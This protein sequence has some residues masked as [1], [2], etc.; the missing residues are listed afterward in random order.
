MENSKW[1]T[2]ES[3]DYEPNKARFEPYKHVSAVEIAAGG[4][5][6]EAD[7]QNKSTPQ[8]SKGRRN[9]NNQGNRAKANKPKANYYGKGKGRAN[10]THNGHRNHQNGKNKAQGS[11]LPHARLAN[12]LPSMSGDL[13]QQQEADFLI[14]P[15]DGLPE[16]LYIELILK[17]QGKEISRSEWEHMVEG[18]IVGLCMS[19]ESQP[20]ANVAQQAYKARPQAEEPY[21]DRVG[22]MGTKMDNVQLAGLTHPTTGFNWADEE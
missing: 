15:V 1:A 6:S 2:K 4:A 5:Q 10:D 3:E 22:T 18:A 16:N 13:V 8:D 20:E 12:S 17:V 19:G 21:P 14:P 11:M 7:K 9:M